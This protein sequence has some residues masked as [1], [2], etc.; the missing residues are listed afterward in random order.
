[1]APAQP[2]PTLARRERRIVF[3]VAVASSVAAIAARGASQIHFGDARA[4]ILAAQL[5]LARHRYPDWTDL[6]I[7]RPPGY[8]I[9]LAAATAGHPAAVALAKGWN[10][11]LH[12]LNALLVAAL[13][14]RI[15]ASRPVARTS[16]LAAAVAPSLLYLTTGVQS[17]PLFLCLL[18]GAGFLLLAAADRPSSGLACAAGAVLALAALT[19]PAALCLAP[20]LA[21]PSFDR[22]YP[23]RIGTSL[24]ASALLGLCLALGPWT[25]RN[26]I[27]FRA[28]LPV[29]DGAGLVLYQGN[30]PWAVAY[31]RARSRREIGSW[32]AAYSRAASSRFAYEVPGAGDA[33]PARRSAALARAALAWVRRNPA[34]EAWLLARKLLDW[35]RPW[36]DPRTW[37]PWVAWATGAAYLLLYALAARGLWNARR[38]GVALAAVAVLALSTAFHVLMLVAWRYRMVFWDPILLLYGTAGGLDLLPIRAR[39]AA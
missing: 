19:R 21:A 24:S 4:Y 7:F 30:S 1:M 31:Y 33:N 22:R 29:N 37:G 3:S 2:L 32:V 36:A 17:E 27:R 20:L 38:R 12:G 18:L 39:S 5:L 26:A 11:I 25:L 13:G 16:G 8:P 34:G 9:F 6:T 23:R 15:F 10:A 28:F 35:I 14:G